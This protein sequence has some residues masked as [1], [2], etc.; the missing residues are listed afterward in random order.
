MT[1]LSSYKSLFSPLIKDLKKLESEG[2]NVGIGKSVCVT[3]AYISGSNLGN[4]WLGGFV[5]NFL[6]S[7]YFCRYCHVS[8]S[9]SFSDPFSVGNIR[10]VTSYKAALQQLDQSP[11]EHVQG[12]E[13]DSAFNEMNF[14]HVCSPA[15]PRCVGHDIFERVLRLHLS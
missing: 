14:Y 8:S 7:S 15:L 10:K 13:Y 6:S 9:M 11:G 12:I 1:S 2:I 3:V 4:H 5:Y